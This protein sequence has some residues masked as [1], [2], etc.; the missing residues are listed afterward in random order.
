MADEDKGLRLED[1]IGKRVTVNILTE[2]ADDP[3]DGPVEIEGFLEGVDPMGIIVLFGQGDVQTERGP[4]G[5]QP[6][7][8]RHVFYP[9]RRIRSVERIEGE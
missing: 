9:W 6:D 4:V 7:V 2:P 3:A 1:W 5:D 8:P